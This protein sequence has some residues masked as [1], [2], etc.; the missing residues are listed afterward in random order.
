M[1]LAE[2]KFSIRTLLFIVSVAAVGLYLWINSTIRIEN[3]LSYWPSDIPSALKGQQITVF[4]QDTSAKQEHYNTNGCILAV[5][6]ADI[7]KTQIT[8]RLNPWSKWKIM[9]ADP[10]RVGWYCPYFNRGGSVFD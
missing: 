4:V 6:P 10:D 2:I 5:E 7:S 9:S 3:D 1:E 8:I